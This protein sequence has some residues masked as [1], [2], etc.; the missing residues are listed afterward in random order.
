MIFAKRAV[1]IGCI[2]FAG[3][4]F[5]MLLQ[6]LLPMQHLADAKTAI[7][8]IQSLMTLL[9]A[10]VLGLLIG[11]SYGVYSQQQSE[12]QTLGSQILQLDLTLEHYGPEADRGREDL[13]RLASK[14]RHNGANLSRA[15]AELGISRQRAYRLLE[16][17][18]VRELLAELGH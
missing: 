4:L 15:C 17:R 13:E 10:L 6:R 14:L 1:L 12:A 3:C 7:T 18:S 9:L 8:T 5:G 11:T 16:G 2:I